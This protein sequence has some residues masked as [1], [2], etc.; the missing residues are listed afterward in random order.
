MKVWCITPPHTVHIWHRQPVNCDVG[1]KLRVP[2]RA[3]ATGNE[4]APPPHFRLPGWGV[5]GG[6]ESNSYFRPVI[7]WTVSL[8]LTSY[9]AFTYTLRGKMVIPFKPENFGIWFLEYAQLPRQKTTGY[10]IPFWL[11]FQH[12]NVQEKKYQCTVPT[13]CTI[14]PGWWINR[15]WCAIC[16]CLCQEW[17]NGKNTVTKELERNCYCT[18][19]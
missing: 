3:S 7:S 12:D 13:V 9:P 8:A 17:K 5:G 14:V 11:L 16:K 2:N 1:R 6:G 4:V 15:P 18:F 10:S 19:L